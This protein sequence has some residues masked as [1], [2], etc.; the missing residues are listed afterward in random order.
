MREPERVPGR[1]A[2]ISRNTLRQ[3][4]RAPASVRAEVIAQGRAIADL[5]RQLAEAQGKLDA[6]EIW[7]K[8]THCCQSCAK[9]WLARIL[10][11][12]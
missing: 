4:A 7:S 1:T 2:S 3:L 11:G 9:R 6:V 8:A 12:E 10:K 5:E